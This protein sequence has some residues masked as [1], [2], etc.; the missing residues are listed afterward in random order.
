MENSKRV[1]EKRTKDPACFALDQI[2][3]TKHGLTQFGRPYSTMDTFGE[4]AGRSKLIAV[5]RFSMQHRKE[6]L[7][8]G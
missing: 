8:N 4:L 3:N 6:Q 7:I 1:Q 2:W 5:T